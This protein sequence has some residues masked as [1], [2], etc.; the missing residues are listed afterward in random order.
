VSAADL[1]ARLRESRT[2]LEARL[3]ESHTDLEARLRE[4][5]SELETDHETA[6][7]RQ[8]DGATLGIWVFL[9]SEVLFFGALF[10]TYT[11]ARLANQEACAA[12]GRATNK[13]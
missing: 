8:R 11:A 5:W 13:G 6:F 2:D 3:R 10:L 12:A 4:P 9:A 7:A 1:E